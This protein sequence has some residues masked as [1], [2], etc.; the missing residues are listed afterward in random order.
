MR[1]TRAALIA[2]C[3]IPLFSAAAFAGEGYFPE[4]GSARIGNGL[5]VYTAPAGEVALVSLRLVIDAGSLYD[6]PGL[7]G[8]SGLAASLLMEGV[9]GPGG[10]RIYQAAESLGG[11]IAVEKGRDVVVIEGSFMAEDIETGIELLSRI[12]ISPRFTRE[13]LE[14]ERD[15]QASEIGSRRYYQLA[16]DIFLEVSLP[17]GYS[18]PV[19]GYRE[20]LEAITAEDIME[21]YRKYYRPGRS[22]LVITGSMESSSALELAR[23][24]FGEWNAGGAGREEPGAGGADPGPAERVLIIDQPGITQSEIRIGGAGPGRGTADYYPLTLGNKILGQG[25][26]SRLYRTLRDDEGLVYAVRTAAGYFRDA[27]YFG[28]YTYCG[29]DRVRRVIDEVVSVL[30]SFV[31]QPVGEAELSGAKNFFRGA[32]PLLMET[33]GQI[34]DRIV[35][36]HNF[37][38]S[39]K[40]FSHFADSIDV[41]SANRVQDSVTRHFL[42][43]SR[44]IVVLTDYSETREQFAGLGPLEVL[45]RREAEGGLRNPAPGKEQ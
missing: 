16:T 2:F 34:A 27:G 21:F 9:E 1:L 12:A 43:G 32:L 5:T 24:Y 42:S 14:G 8:I 17:A 38:L 7:E 20:T 15:Y 28:V 31:G 33:S 6:P 29:N 36:I 22:A 30:D 44:V 25:R 18:H 13:Q 39:A 37:G 23:E 19:S 11:R 45:T 10:N 35:D 4:Y 40:S 26:T 3:L 41:L